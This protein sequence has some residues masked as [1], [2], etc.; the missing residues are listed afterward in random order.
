MLTRTLGRWTDRT[1]PPLALLAAV[2]TSPL[3]PTAVVASQAVVDG[4]AMESVSTVSRSQAPSY[5]ALGKTALVLSGGSAAGFTHIGVIQALE[6][7]GVRPDLIVGT[8]MGAGIGALYASGYTGAEID[9]IT[10]KYSLSSVFSGYGPRLPRPLDERPALVVLEKRGGGFSIDLTTADERRALELLN[11]ALLRGNL[12]AGGDFDSLPIPFRAV[13]TDLIQRDPV[14]LDSGDLVRA[15]RASL[16]LPIIFRP[17]Q[18]D[19][20]WLVDGAFSANLPIDVARALGAD[21]VIASDA[22]E[23]IDPGELNLESPTEMT[24]ALMN[25]WVQQGDT[26]NET[27]LL[28][29]GDIAGLPRLDFSN[30][31]KTAF[32]EEGYRAAKAAILNARCRPPRSVQTEATWTLPGSDSQRRALDLFEISNE[33]IGVFLNP[34]A[35]G[36]SVY[37]EPEI[38]P[39]PRA[40]IAFGAAYTREMGGKAWLGASS[41]KVAG[42]R[43]VGSFVLAGGGLEQELEAGIRTARPS[44]RDVTPIGTVS[45]ARERVRHFDAEGREVPGVAA[46]ISRG[47]IGLERNLKRGWVAS[48]GPALS[49]WS[50]G[51]VSAR[52]SSVG[53]GFSLARHGKARLPS[54]RAQ[55]LLGSAYD[56]LSFEASW[57]LRVGNTRVTPELRLGWGRGLP[58][59]EMLSLGGSR[60]FPGLHLG[61]GRSDTEALLRVSASHAVIGPIRLRVE[62]DAATNEGY[63]FAGE[64]SWLAGGRAGLAVDTFFGSIALEYGSNNVGR[65]AWQFRVGQWFE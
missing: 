45:V 46:W 4:V 5:C 44:F 18:V 63:T 36:D 29:R 32:V 48:A 33:E 24:R 1:S 40:V 42:G 55:G 2:A 52:R 51:P 38:I 31:R 27:D 56:R 35:A 16:S 34:R 39:A 6:E 21:F 23:R 54:L 60:G 59:Q 10:T 9:S 25:R 49:I 30:A 65:R 43:L 19:G 47:A 41:R 61:E 26:V 53:L 37:F 58:V 64:Q 57:P 14:V 28:I 12:L 11:A 3:I 7:W 17:V 13:A 50:D 8:S 22:T 15:V 20:R 62:A